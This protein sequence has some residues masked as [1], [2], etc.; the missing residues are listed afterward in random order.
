[1]RIDKLDLAALESTLRAYRDPDRV[2]EEIPVLR[3]LSRTRDQLERGAREFAARLTAVLGDGAAVDVCPTVSEAGG[4]ALPGVEL[5]SWAVTVRPHGEGV[6]VWE[7]RL[8]R[9]RPAVFARVT[10]DRLMF[11][12][13]T[14]Q[15]EDFAPIED[16]LLAA[17][18]SAPTRQE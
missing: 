11:D 18:G 9:H 4:G 14:V 7:Q 1:M 16:A 15:P 5:P 10:E 8:R 13:R 12:L 17:A 6:E 2:W 3:M